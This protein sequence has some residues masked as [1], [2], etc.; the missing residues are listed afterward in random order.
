MIKLDTQPITA[1]KSVQQE[2]DAAGDIATSEKKVKDECAAQSP[3]PIQTTRT[4]S[5]E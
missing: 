2:P 3:F 4:L 1:G 5:R